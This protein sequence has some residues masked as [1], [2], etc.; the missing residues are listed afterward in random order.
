MNIKE[1]E[2]LTGVTKQNIRFYEKKGL[3]TPDRN[4]QNDYREYTEDDV[5]ILQTIKMFRKLEISIEDIRRILNQEVELGEMIEKHLKELTDQQSHLKASIEI[6]RQLTDKN[7]ESLNVPEVLEKMQEIERRGGKF[8]DIIEDYK[9][10]VECEGKKE[11]SFVPDT[12]ALTPREFTDALLQFA[13]E[14][15]LNITITKESM[16][17]RFLLDGIEYEAD[18]VFSR[19]GAVIRLHMVNPE[20][21]EARDVPQERREKMIL[22]HRLMAPVI[23]IVCVLLFWASRQFTLAS[24]L[25]ALSMAIIWIAYL[26]VYRNIR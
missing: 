25:V 23:M 15:N 9:K 3:L 17:P 2:R 22:V 1:L 6:C 18:R 26:I 11:F 5:A 16:Y 12:M 13:N 14:N 19:L 8:M 7:L 10:V 24:L 21:G 20:D 4:P